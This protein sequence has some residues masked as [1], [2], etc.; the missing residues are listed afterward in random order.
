[1]LRT[2]F[3]MVSPG[4]DFN[5]MWTN[6]N[7]L[8]ALETW[9]GNYY[10][11][12]FSC[13]LH[14]TPWYLNVLIWHLSFKLQCP[15][16]D[17]PSSGT[18]SSCSTRSRTC[19]ASLMTCICQWRSNTQCSG[20]WFNYQALISDDPTKPEVCVPPS[21]CKSSA[22]LLTNV[23]WYMEN[24]YTRQVVF[25]VCPSMPYCSNFLNLV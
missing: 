14:W 20:M 16:R 18:L 21:I 4:N 10:S 19:K 23:V 9:T 25:P 24:Y 12:I 15:L 1:M 6:I 17:F 5:S 13:R 7:H 11:L 3:S 8:P 22:L 2:V